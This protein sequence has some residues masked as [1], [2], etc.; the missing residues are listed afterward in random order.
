MQKA[1]ALQRGGFGFFVLSGIAIC[2]QAPVTRVRRPVAPLGVFC[3]LKYYGQNE[4]NRVEPDWR[5]YNESLKRVNAV[6]DRLSISRARLPET[7]YAQWGLRLRGAA[8]RGEVL[9]SVPA[10]ACIRGVSTEK[11]VP[12]KLAHILDELPLSDWRQRL[13]IMLLRKSSAPECLLRDFADHCPLSPPGTIM[14]SLDP[15]T[16]QGLHDPYLRA[17]SEERMEMLRQMSIELTSALDDMRRF[18]LLDFSGPRDFE[19]A[20][21]WAVNCAASRAFVPQAFSQDVGA[22]PKGISA[23][24]AA[25]S[26]TAPDA[27]ETLLIPV[28]DMLNHVSDAASSTCTI[29]YGA[30]GSAV[31]LVAV[32]SIEDGEALTAF[33]GPLSNDDL[34]VDFGFVDSEN[35]HDAVSIDL[36]PSIITEAQELRELMEGDV[37]LSAS[38]MAPSADGGDAG[39]SYFAQEDR[40]V[41][42]EEVPAEVE[43]DA[44]QAERNVLEPWRLIWLERLRFSGPNSDTRLVMRKTPD[45]WAFVDR[46]YA[47]MHV[48]AA[49]HE[50]DVH[51]W[52]AIGRALDALA[53]GYRSEL[54]VRQREEMR[55]SAYRRLAGEPVKE[56]YGMVSGLCAIRVKDLRGSVAEDEGM[57]DLLTKLIESSE[58]TEIVEKLHRLE[59]ETHKDRAFFPL[60]PQGMEKE[61]LDG[62]E[63][64]LDAF[65]R[66]EKWQDPSSDASE[67]HV[68]ALLR[69]RLRAHELLS[70]R[71]SNDGLTRLQDLTRRMLAINCRLLRSPA[72]RAAA[73]EASQ[74]RFCRLGIRHGLGLTGVLP[75]DD[76]ERVRGNFDAIRADAYDIA[77]KLAGGGFDLEEDGRDLL[78]AAYDLK[79]MLA[80]ALEG[81]VVEDFLE[82]L[83]VVQGTIALVSKSLQG[84]T[85]GAVRTRAMQLLERGH[86]VRAVVRAAE[87]LPEAV[88]EHENLAVTEAAFLDLSDEQIAA[89]TSGCDAVASC[90]GHNLSFSGIWGE[91]RRLCLDSA[92]RVCEAVKAQ[93]GGAAKKVKYV[94]M[95]TVGVFNEDEAEAPFSTAESWIMATLRLALPPH[96]DNEEA[97][98]YFRST[99]GQDDASVE[100]A[101][102]RPD[103]LKDVDE[104]TPYDVFQKQQ[105]S[106]IFGEGT[107]S[108]INV[109]HFMA[110]LITDGD[111]WNTWK[112]KMPT[113]YD[114]VEKAADA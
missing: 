109:A 58:R 100:W 94:L 40:E 102:A 35:A 65:N 107:T 41:D 47:A 10:S 97:A 110:E 15:D 52:E 33:Y 14:G 98:E 63:R 36:S 70:L 16:L 85:L 46:S 89:L 103:D 75:G 104:V 87:R 32:R 80:L 43:V 7:P 26:P 6:T 1:L 30:D 86:H 22:V 38:A 60:R 21:A 99:I 66:L 91:P 12:E 20:A 11:D 88:R 53:S 93:G 50:S 68:R 101:V 25:A 114:R 24:A 57:S 84:K 67:I 90:L 95:G 39:G 29:R 23:A 44:E 92:R 45:G 17:R 105:Y 113:I 83:A 76:V 77:V 108:R 49:E 55:E 74:K 106:P 62:L 73:L 111:K 79:C 78:A 2:F 82:V 64:Q 5:R 3:E 9:A 61:L 71:L 51:G 96:V 48:L 27:S 19:L 31:E 18:G 42:Q 4:A 54:S 72:W 81:D 34:L 56:V 69:V 28:F 13:A 112:G 37:K 59:R 8:E